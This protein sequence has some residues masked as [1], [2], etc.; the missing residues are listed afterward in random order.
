MPLAIISICLVLSVVLKNPKWKKRLFALGLS[1]LLLFSNEFIA[2]EIMRAWEVPVTPYQDIKKKYTYG[3]LLSGAARTEVGPT[4]RVYILSA[5]DRIN[6][7]VQLYK[8]GY[9]SKVLISGGNGRL[10]TAEREADALFSLL[11]LMG[12]PAE[13]MLVENEAR[14][15]HE[16][17]I[18]VPRLLNGKATPEDCLLITSA[19]HMRR[20]RACFN[21]VGWHL[22]TFSADVHSHFRKFSPDVLFI[23]KIE[24]LA[25]WQILFKEWVGLTAYWLAGYV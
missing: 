17:A 15:T 12:I 21:K 4:D 16:S 20:S 9:I 25:N 1:M 5:A 3:I 6:H 10:V 13:D 23:P 14:N 2:N 22:D 11:Q 18:Y 19:F 7:T 8:L 24:A